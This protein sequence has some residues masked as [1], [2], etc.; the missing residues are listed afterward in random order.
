[1]FDIELAIEN[2]AEPDATVTPAIK[3]RYPELSNVF[4]RIDHMAA[5]I[6]ENEDA[7]TVPEADYEELDTCLTSLLDGL[8]IVS[9]MLSTLRKFDAVPESIAPELADLQTRLDTEMRDA[10]NKANY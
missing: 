3:Q 5:V 4:A 6:E 2:M 9:E 7:R 10:A 8:A 1:M